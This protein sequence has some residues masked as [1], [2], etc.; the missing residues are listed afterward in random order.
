MQPMRKENKAYKINGS[1]FYSFLILTDRPI[2]WA[3]D[4]IE[5]DDATN[6]K[7]EQGL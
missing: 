3:K 2:I 1:C 7:R 5:M 6:Q 4:L